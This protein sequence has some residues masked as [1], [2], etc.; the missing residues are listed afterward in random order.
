[1]CQ[2]EVT[3]RIVQVI[4]GS[5]GVFEVLAGGVIGCFSSI[6]SG[7]IILKAQEKGEVKK[8]KTNL[9]DELEKNIEN[10]K[11]ISKKVDIFS[12]ITKENLNGFGM[13]SFNDHKKRLFLI[14]DQKIRRGLEQFYA[15]LKKEITI[16]EAFVKSDE[17]MDI[18]PPI[19]K[20]IKQLFLRSDSPFVLP[21]AA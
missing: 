14:K 9:I 8:I 15:K 20:N 16:T 19:V 5:N 7:I 18:L 1:M 3:G 21:F 11:K 17:R 6:F 12:A 4:E 10:A 2:V 13:E